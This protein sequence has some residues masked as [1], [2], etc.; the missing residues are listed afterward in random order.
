[1]F[2]NFRADNLNFLVF[3]HYASLITTIDVAFVF[4]LKKIYLSEFFGSKLIKSNNF[5]HLRC[6]H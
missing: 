2:E 4:I 1:M 5:I 6:C 3:T